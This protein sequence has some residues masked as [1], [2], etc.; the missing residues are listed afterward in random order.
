MFRK[1]AF[2]VRT[3]TAEHPLATVPRQPKRPVAPDELQIPNLKTVRAALIQI[4][5]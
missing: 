2:D 3:A 1:G 5:T 4:R